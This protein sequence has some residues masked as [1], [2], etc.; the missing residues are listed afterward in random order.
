M[1]LAPG[2][3]SGDCPEQVGQR[4]SG[5]LITREWVWIWKH[6]RM[7]LNMD[8]DCGCQREDATDVDV[9][10]VPFGPPVSQVQK[11]QGKECIARRQ[12]SCTDKVTQEVGAVANLHCR[13]SRLRQEASPVGLH[14]KSRFFASDQPGHSMI[15]DDFSSSRPPG[16]ARPEGA[17]KKSPGTIIR[18]ELDGYRDSNDCL[19]REAMS[20]WSSGM[21]VS[22]SEPHDRQGHLV[23]SQQGG[24]GPSD[25]SE[26]P[27]CTR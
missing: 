9:V 5:L 2:E 19:T 20:S 14:L 23:L 26:K 17:H 27:L 7:Q 10:V 15:F 13:E 11:L 6:R 16:D 12:V 1:R 25:A 18:L 21:A 4:A 24:R 3:E 22:V 8:V